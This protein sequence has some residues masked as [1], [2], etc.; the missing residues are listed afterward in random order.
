MP[1]FQYRGRNRQGEAVSGVVESPSS[2][3]AA[4]QLQGSGVTPIDIRPAPPVR[5]DRS[6]LPALLRPRPSL[7]D[8]ILF[9]R[10]LYTVQRTGIPILRGMLTLIETT[11]NPVLAEAL[12]DV[13]ERL[14]AGRDLSGALARH[15]GI[16]SNLFVR[17]V[18]AGEQSG[19]LDAALL[20]VSEHLVLEKQTR[21]R[22]KSALRYPAI[23]VLAIAI[24]VGVINLLVIPA[25]ARVFERFDAELPL[26]TRILIGTSDFMVANW[27]FLAAG[28]AGGYFLLLRY[29]RTPAG[30]YQ[31]DR[32]KLRLPVVGSIILRITLSRVARSF[33]M[34]SRSGVPIIQAMGVVGQASD[35]RYVESRVEQVRESVERGESISRSA[36]Q[37]GLFPPLVLQMMGIGEETGTLDEMMEEVAG[38]YDREVDYDLKTL[39]DTIEPILIVAVGVM[40]LILAL[41]V[42]LPMWDLAATAGR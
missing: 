4:E 11:R 39:A 32:L 29:L 23:V 26:P 3:A 30:R 34:A 27:P 19:Q 36:A 17:I 9:A 5:A 42:F 15:P 40:V 35:N 8:L 12:R 31:W 2:A 25:F 28:L 37:T 41:G 21:E 14:E 38:F 18:Q 33:A 6:S 16:F 7:D 24:A 22:I 20:Q 10:Q 1:A 13:R